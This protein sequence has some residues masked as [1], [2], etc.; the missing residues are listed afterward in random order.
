LKRAGLEDILGGDLGLKA[1]IE[2]DFLFFA[3]LCYKK[4]I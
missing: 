2:A 3:S 4:W 1:E